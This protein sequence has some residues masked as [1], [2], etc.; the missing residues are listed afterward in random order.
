MEDFFDFSMLSMRDS[1]CTNRSNLKSVT[2]MN[3]NINNCIDSLPLTMAYVPMQNFEKTYEPEA[4][5][6]EGTIF[7]ELNKPFYGCSK[8]WDDVR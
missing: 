7:P 6:S 3:N 5:L 4:G 8:R 1:D 2:R